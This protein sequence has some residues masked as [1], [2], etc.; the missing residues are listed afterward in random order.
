MH[1]QLGEEVQVDKQLHAFW[2]LESLGITGEKSESPEDLEALQRF[3]ET[4]IFKDGCYQVE[5]P[6]RQEHPALQDNYQVARKR[7]KGLKRKLRKDVTL[8]GRY[9]D[10]VE[11]YLQQ[12]M[13][14]D[15]PQDNA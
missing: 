12:G 3:E 1:I 14:E 7:L 4:S 13:A 2:E 8:C 5:L 15:V 9:N 10:V 11:D 6:W